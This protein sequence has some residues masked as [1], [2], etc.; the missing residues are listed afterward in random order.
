MNPYS[1]RS[2]LVFATAI[3]CLLIASDLSAQRRDREISWVNPDIPEMRG[4]TH[5]VLSSEKMGH[6]V[7]YVVW[8]PPGFEAS[9]TVRYPVVYF[10][11]GMGGSEKSDAA[12]FS[13][14][15]AKA[16]E[17]NEFPEAIC[18]F[19]NGG[20][21][22]YRGNVESMIIE[23]LIPLV[24]QSYPTVSHYS[25]RVICGFSMGG[26][27]SI[28]LSLLHPELF[29]GAGSWGGALSWRGSPSESPLLPIAEKNA[30]QLKKQQFAFLAI[31]GDEDRPNAFE[32]LA[33]LLRP[34]GIIFRT[35]TLEETKHSLGRYYELSGATMVTFLAECLRR[36]H[37]SPR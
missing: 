5:K 35:T 29:C 12:G 31:N 22:G 32:P 3:S 34:F 7:G 2:I 25:G 20:R 9:G 18:I 17:A 10:L 33:S 24:D 19:P 14:R 26:A 30:E 6:D 1:R 27:G 13:A 4:L 23:E 15:V 8:T 16:I 28:R 37:V 21:S 36:G 11:H